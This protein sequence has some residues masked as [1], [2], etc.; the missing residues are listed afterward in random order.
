M[1]LSKVSVMINIVFTKKTVLW[2]LIIG[3]ATVLIIIGFGLTSR[4]AI[5]DPNDIMRDTIAQGIQDNVS[6]LSCVVLVWNSERKGF[7]PWANKPEIKGTH[8][9]WWIKN[10]TAISS[11]IITTVTDPNGQVST[12]QKITFMTY[13]GKK[14]REAEMPTGPKGKVEIGI[15]RKPA[16]RFRQNNYLQ[17]IGWQGRGGLNRISK[18]TEPGVEHWLTE[19]NKTIEQTFHNTRTGQVGVWTYDVEKGYGLVSKEYYFKE[20][21][22]QLRTIIQYKQVSGGAWFPVSVVNKNF[23]IQNGELIYCSKMDVD[24]NK[25]VFNDPSAIPDDVFELEIGPNDEVTDLTSLKTRL[26]RFLNDF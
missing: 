3:L 18:P 20:D 22:L 12:N 24:I 5:H 2:F 6:K 25:S 8:Q 9:L 11:D 4:W 26:K 16:G 14:F 13:D 23:N 21:I 15:S 19:E 1:L 10:K 17:S 7:G